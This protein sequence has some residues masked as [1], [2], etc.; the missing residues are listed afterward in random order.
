MPLNR[1]LF[2]VVPALAALGGCATYQARDL[3]PA[4]TQ[5]QLDRR[6]LTDPGLEKY[7][8]RHLLPAAAEWDLSRLTLAAFYFNPELAVA[9]AQLA[10][11]EAGVRTAAARPN[12]TFSFSPGR[13]ENSSG[14][15]TPWI[16]GYA[17]D[18]PVELA[19][20]RGYRTAEARHHLDV[21]RFN[22]A[23][24]AWTIRS[25]VR[26]ALT[27][28]RGSEATAELWRKQTPLLER[29][30]QLV[31]AQVAAG[32]A[33]PLQAAQARV[34]LN[35]AALAVRES[36]RA[37]LSARSDLAAAI[38]VPLAALANTRLDTAELAGTGTS[39]ATAEA[40]SWAAQNRADLLASLASYAAAQA[41]LQYEIARQYPDLKVGPGYQFDQGEGKW[42]LSLGFELPVFH[43]N[44][45]PIAVAEARREVESSRFLALQ[46]RVL[47]EVD[48]AAGAY[49]LSLGEVEMIATLRA[50]LERQTKIVRA[51]QAAGETS[52][53]ELIRSEI[54]LADQARAEI[55]ARQRVARALTDL[56]AAV[57]RP[58]SWPESSWRTPA[59][60]A[61]P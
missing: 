40:R 12:P 9:R 37:V 35:R 5:E 16:L 60:A 50:S 1:R 11:A 7:L 38:G 55:E 6:Q 17:L 49:D 31:D 10:E 53:L 22:L 26:R 14:G 3:T 15:V 34:A 57:Q 33:S 36:E 43:Q 42:S 19:G 46:H 41:A 58:L 2:F 8:V 47:A 29:A 59:V 30:A 45:G 61:R 27:D 18:I 24:L 32:D 56:E 4:K 44:Q 23:S 48:R 39:L 54:E 13:N 28:L 52:R 51:Q 20:K 21:A 25:A